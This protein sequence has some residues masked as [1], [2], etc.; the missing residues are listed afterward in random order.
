[1]TLPEDLSGGQVSLVGSYLYAVP[2]ALAE[3]QPQL[4]G[5]R[6]LHPGWWLGQ[7]AGPKHPSDN[8][9]GPVSDRAPWLGRRPARAGFQTDPKQDRFEPSHALALGLRLGD[10]RLAVDL[11]PDS[12]DL[13]AYLRGL[14]LAHTGENGWVLVGVGGYPLGWAKRVDGRLKSHYPKG[15]RPV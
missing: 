4:A 1:V 2:P 13:S 5:L 9:R 15:L 8:P 14:T 7:L 11:P 6:F 3:V 10:G 12:P